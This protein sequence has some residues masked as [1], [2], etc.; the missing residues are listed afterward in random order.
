MRDRAREA[1]G[2]APP[3]DDDQ[4]ERTVRRIDRPD[5]GVAVEFAMVQFDVRIARDLFGQALMT[6]GIRPS[7]IM[8]SM[9]WIAK[10]DADQRSQPY[11]SLCR[12]SSASFSIGPRFA[13]VC[14]PRRKTVWP[15]ASSSP[16]SRAGARVY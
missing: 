15:T 11:L 3:V 1:F 10:S 6:C 2:A 4:V 12:A 9:S 16:A 13:I 14:I 5:I 7:A 8:R